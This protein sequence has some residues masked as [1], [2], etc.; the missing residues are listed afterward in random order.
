MRIAYQGT[1]LPKRNE[2]I[3]HRTDW[4]IRDI[5]NLFLPVDIIHLGIS[6]CSIQK[7]S[8]EC[9]WD[10]VWPVLRCCS[11]WQ[12]QNCMLG[13]IWPSRQTEGWACCTLIE[14]RA[15]SFLSSIRATLHVVQNCGSG[16]VATESRATMR[17]ESYCR[18]HWCRGRGHWTPDGSAALT[19]TS[20]LVLRAIVI[21]SFVRHPY[22]KVKYIWSRHGETSQEMLPVLCS[23]PLSLMNAVVYLQKSLLSVVTSTF[24]V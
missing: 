9:S 12:Q 8:C 11:L 14:Q 22:K 17:V 13:Y 5:P 20:A 16:E 15:S 7:M 18:P 6:C 4:K 23:V 19:L 2:A 1:K 10:D 3:V 24:S 21:S